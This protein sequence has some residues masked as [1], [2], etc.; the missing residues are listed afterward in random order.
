[1]DSFRRAHGKPV[2]E[3]TGT[4]LLLLTIQLAV[5][6]GSELAPVAIGI[7][8]MTA[9]YAGG[10]IS[11]AHYNPAVSLAVYLRGKMEL[12]EMLMYWAFQIV[13]GCIGALLA[14]FIGGSYAVCAIGNEATFS[15]AMVAEICFTFFLC[16]VVLGTATSSAA[17]GNSYFG[18]SIGLTVTAG[19]FS[20]GGISGGAFNPAVALGL[21]F[22]SNGLSDMGYSSYVA[23]ADLIGGAV[24]AGLYFLVAPSSEFSDYDSV[25]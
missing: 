23:L 20:V 8:L 18:A 10:P 5:G 4:A 11:G 2:M 12:K 17:N 19:A 22:A 25:V 16:F 9:V 15:Q 14:G 21:T 1:M 13:G 24:A 3:L 6:S 7:A